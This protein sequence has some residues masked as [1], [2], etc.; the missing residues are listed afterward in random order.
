MFPRHSTRR[1]RTPGAE[2]PETGFEMF[3]S[4]SF[5]LFANV[6]KT[7]HSPEDNAEEFYLQ[8]EIL[9]EPSFEGGTHASSCIEGIRSRANT[10]YRFEKAN[11]AEI[12]L[13]EALDQ[14]M[15]CIGIGYF[16]NYYCR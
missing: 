14:C 11:K 15:E 9:E 12:H 13:R 3:H 5:S 4:S 8:G 2:N 10:K 1:I 7:T 6:L 16:M